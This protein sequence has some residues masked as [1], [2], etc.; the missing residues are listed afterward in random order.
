MSTVAWIHLKGSRVV[1]L[2]DRYPCSLVIIWQAGDSKRLVHE[3]SLRFKTDALKL[4]KHSKIDPK[5]VY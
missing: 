2:T 1:L 3:I 4:G 5:C